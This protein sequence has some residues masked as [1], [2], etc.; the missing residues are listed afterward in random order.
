MYYNSIIYLDT[1]T[2]FIRRSYLTASHVQLIN[3]NVIEQLRAFFGPWDRD[4]S[5]SPPC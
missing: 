4:R 3:R 2:F 5:Q 1:L